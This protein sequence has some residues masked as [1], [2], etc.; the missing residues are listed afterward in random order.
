MACWHLY[1]IRT[2][3]H[4]IYAGISTDVRRR[5]KEHLAQGRKAAKYLLAH[6]PQSLAFSLAIGD[7]AL[8]LRV[9]HHFKQLSKKE[10][11]WI[12]DSQQLIF[13]GDSGR[14]QSPEQDSLA[15]WFFESQG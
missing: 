4:S 3:D 6:K 7:R 1:I 2:V 11:E 8:A 12:V 5:F 13:A 14:I 10:K 15:Q 9:E